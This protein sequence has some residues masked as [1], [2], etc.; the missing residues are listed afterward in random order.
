LPT[1]P[2]P[3]QT[4]VR[5]ERS[6]STVSIASTGVPAPTTEAVLGRAVTAAPPGV[7]A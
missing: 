4:M 5:T 2:L 1:P 7:P 6:S 3:Q